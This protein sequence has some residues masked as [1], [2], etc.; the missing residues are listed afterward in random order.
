LSN[1]VVLTDS[2]CSRWLSALRAG[3]RRVAQAAAETHQQQGGMAAQFP[4]EPAAIAVTDSRVIVVPGNGLRFGDPVMSIGRGSVL[5]RSVR[6]H[7]FGRRIEL[8]FADG[9]GVEV[10]ASMGQS[11]RRLMDLLGTAP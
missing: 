7:G 4:G 10:D 11:F 9:T 3:A 6:R 5:V 8:V 1:R 2:A